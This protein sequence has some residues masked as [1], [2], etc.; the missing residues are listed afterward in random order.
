MRILF[1]VSLISICLSSFG[2][3]ETGK[4][5]DSVLVKEIK[6]F[7]DTVNAYY[8]SYESRNNQYVVYV[9]YAYKGDKGQEGTCLTLGYVINS[10]DSR[11]I[12]PT[13]YFKIDNEY[14]LVRL[15]K[16]IKPSSFKGIDLVKFNIY[17]DDAIKII[18]KLYPSA[19]GGFTYHPPGMTFCWNGEDSNRTYYENADEIPMNKSIWGDFPQGGQIDLIR[20]RK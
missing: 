9:L 6:W 3:L 4:G 10:N 5:S 15:G 11:Y 20:E 13:Y 2:Q 7:M 14:V 8:H 17:N 12:L 19:L 18:Q 1:L 16:G